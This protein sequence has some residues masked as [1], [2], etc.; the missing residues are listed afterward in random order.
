MLAAIL[1]PPPSLSGYSLSLSLSPSTYSLPCTCSSPSSPLPIVF[2]PSSFLVSAALSCWARTPGQ[3]ARSA[4][5][6]RA[7][8]LPRL[9]CTFENA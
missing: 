5:K 1:F 6:A 8:W 9:P 4:S 2:L 3:Q 7:P